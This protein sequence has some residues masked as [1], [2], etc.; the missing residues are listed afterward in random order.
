[1][2][3]SRRQIIAL[4]IPASLEAVF[5]MCLG[6][7]D[8]IIIG[9]LGDTA[10][11]AVALTNQVMFLLTLVLGTLASAASI[12]IA[13]AH[14]RGDR[15]SLRST[16]GACVHLGILVSFPLAGL[17]IVVSGPVLELL[18]ADTRVT[19]AGQP[20]LR[21]MLAALPAILLGAVGVGVLRSMGDTRTPML[22][23]LGSVVLNSLLAVLLVSGAGPLPALGIEGAGYATLLAQYARLLTLLLLL[24]RRRLLSAAVIWRHRATGP[25]ARSIVKLAYPMALALILWSVGGLCYT[26]LCGHLGQTALAAN[27]VIVSIEG[28]FFMCAS[29]LGVAGLTIV[30]Q[31]I[32]AGDLARATARSREIIALGLQVSVVM[33]IA[34]LATGWVVPAIYPKLSDQ[35]LTLVVMGLSVNALVQPAKVL[36]LIMGEGVFRAGGDTQFI[37]IANVISIYFIGVPLAILL[38]KVWSLGLLGILIAKSMEEVARVV[39]NLVRYRTRKWCNRLAPTTPDSEHGP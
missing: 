32:G 15:G 10:V 22:V 27:Q 13:Q 16:I 1:M 2:T 31:R 18:G 26:V 25:L 29:G 12:L 4:W 3:D 33:S 23:T 34:V 9:Q 11:A 19:H 17:A 28:V 7:V 5:Q 35:A 36:N 30:G 39:I 6:L 14:G 24:H 37:M 20:F 38:T 8:Q 21:L